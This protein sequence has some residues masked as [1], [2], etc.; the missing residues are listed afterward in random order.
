[1]GADLVWFRLRVV[2]RQRWRAWL[3]LAALVG[4]A[5]GIVL[6]ALAGARRTDS[7]YG[8]FLEASNPFDVVVVSTGTPI[9]YE[10]IRRLPQVVDSAG[11]SY[12]FMAV[13]GPRGQTSFDLSPLL[14]SDDG[15][16]DRIN[17]PRILEGRRPDPS[18][19]EE[20][21]VSRLAAQT[22]GFG[23]GQS[24]TATAFA[25][26][27]AEALFS[28]ERVEPAGPRFVLRVVGIDATPTEFIPTSPNALAMHLTPA[29]TRD[30][31]NQVASIPNRVFK[32][33]RGADD[34]AAFK[35]Q[36]ESLVGGGPVQFITVELDTVQVQRSIHLQAVALRAFAGL[37]A[38][39][40]VLILGQA[41]VRQATA[42]AADHPTLRALG[43]TRGQLWAVAMAQAATVASVGA[44][45][46]VGLASLL[47][48]FAPIGIAG[49]AEPD[50]GFAFDVLTLPLGA[51]AIVV[52]A[53]ALAAGPT[54]WRLRAGASTRS[55]THSTMDRP[56]RLVDSLAGTGLPAP[57]VTGLRMAL[58]PGRGGFVA[59]RNAALVSTVFC[60]GA[61]MVVTT[62]GASL[63]HML[64]TPRLYGWTWDIMA[65]NPYLSDIADEAIP[66]LTSD[67]SVAGVSTVAASEVDIQ[68]VRATALAFE[69]I[70]GSVSP[71]VVEGRG[72]LQPD[73]VLVGTRTLR[74]TGTEIGQTVNV[75][76]GEQTAQV[77]VVGRGV[78]PSVVDSLDVSGLGQGVLFTDEG[79][80]RLVPD[81]P[82]NLFAVR[83]AEGVD[84]GEATRRLTE[85]FPDLT[86]PS[87]PKSVADFGRV[88][89]LPGVLAGLLVVLA[90]ATLGHA[91]PT[92]VR[93]HR[94]QLA[95]LKTLGFVRSQVQATVAVQ[96]TVLMV[97]ALVLGVPLGLAA[98][99]WTW[100]VFADGLGIVPA[101]IVPLAVVL[102]IA[103][104]AVLVANLI[105]AVPGRAAARLQP[106]TAL[107]AE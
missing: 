5:G 37:T 84:T 28:G 15:I 44:M 86:G 6:G 11:L 58:A 14:P 25:P 60:V 75:T 104:V 81:V 59:V 16:Y 80:R 7:A 103:P 43:M 100:R 95:I 8:R 89:A 74:D 50:P 93:H 33:G 3:A 82:R 96:A 26:G 79:L 87:P 70:V 71:P 17:R 21:S 102:G 67:R 78:L 54:R 73:E 36:V 69:P 12:A 52:V 61:V 51:A 98:G 48:V 34:L 77:R 4:L 94:R 62:Y 27:Q 23:V 18:R 56:S 32:L 105:A 90:V 97:G 57:V 101:P 10:A 9:D 19:P 88:D 64:S 41:F 1:M 35:Q 49:D 92:M 76:V 38:I 22:Y 106:A 53:V 85:A 31:G 20:V 68:G 63:R 42:D 24:V 39:A 66:V 29:F 91:M 46:A 30:H 72:P 45:V 107:Q 99:R 40:A 2:A 55:T 47:S 65:G 13:E 83:F